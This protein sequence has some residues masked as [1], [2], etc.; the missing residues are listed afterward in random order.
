MKRVSRIETIIIKLEE[1]K[2]M[3]NFTWCYN[4]EP[5]GEAETPVKLF[6]EVD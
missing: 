5:L 4:F 2:S 6:I 3:Q 1:D